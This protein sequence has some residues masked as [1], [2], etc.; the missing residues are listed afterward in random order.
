M[1]ATAC[2]TKRAG[3]GRSEIGNLRVRRAPVP[4]PD[5]VPRAL[6]ALVYA[7]SGMILAVF[8]SPL[9]DVHEND[10]DRRSVV[11]NGSTDWPQG[12][13]HAVGMNKPLQD[14]CVI[15]SNPDEGESFYVECRAISKDEARR[16]ARRVL[17]KTKRDHFSID[18]VVEVA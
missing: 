2:G 15:A 12:A 3:F 6:A 1:G 14:F 13:A 17:A 18:L 8:E 4:V 11:P 9:R 5:H 16:V 10:N 7:E